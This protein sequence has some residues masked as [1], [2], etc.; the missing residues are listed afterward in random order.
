MTESYILQIL[1]LAEVTKDRF[2]DLYGNDLYVAELRVMRCSYRCTAKVATL[3]LGPRN[4]DES[5]ECELA[6]ARARKRL[7]RL[8]EGSKEPCPP[9]H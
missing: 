8:N 1:H 6:H 7:D 4:R 2:T 3:G 5:A 9:S